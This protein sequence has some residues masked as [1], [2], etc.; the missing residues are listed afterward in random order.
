MEY[1]DKG[2]MFSRSVPYNDNR[3]DPD[4]PEVAQSIGAAIAFVVVI[5]GWAISKIFG[6]DLLG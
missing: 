1:I 5:I 6:R 2:E 3:F 4:H